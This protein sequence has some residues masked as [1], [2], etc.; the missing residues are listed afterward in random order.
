MR[1]N[2]LLAIAAAAFCCIPFLSLAASVDLGYGPDLFYYLSHDAGGFSTFGTISTSGAV[3]DRFGVGIHFDA[4]TFAAPTV[5]YGPNLLY[6]LRHDGGGFSTF[7][8][9]STSGAVTDRFGVG[10]H[11]DAL[12]FAAPDLGYGPN[13]FYYL[14]HDGSGFSTFG[15]ISTSGAVTDRFGVG[16]N[17]NA[18]AFASTNVGY[19]GNLLYYFRRDAAGFSTFGTISTSGAIVD[20]FGVG[21]R[22]DALTFAEV[23][24]QGV[25]RVPPVTTAT[26]SRS[27][28]ANGWHNTDVT[29]TLNATDNEPGGTGVREIDW[30]LIGAQTGT[31]AVPGNTTSLIVNAEGTTTVIYSAIDNAGNRESTRTLRIKLDKTPPVIAGLP[32]LGCSLWPP[33]HKLVQVATVAASDALSGLA[34]FN[35]TG[36]SNESPQPGESDIVITGSA[37]QPRVVELRSE[38]LGVGPGRMY[39]LTATAS[40][41][42]GNTN[43]ATGVC[44]VPHDQGH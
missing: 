9:I 41:L 5:G 23:I 15:T 6:Y 34:S 40:D 24:E 12:T 27:A 16:I 22:F 7:G 1:R 36:T 39:I 26:L 14:R 19:G 37:L 31:G 11:F 25:D 28:N 42:A 10:I 29:V 32:S 3:T 35:V 8:T 13:L 21:F 18:L 44:I 30:L 20:R 43:T 2:Y 17:F 4:L 33:R 38:R